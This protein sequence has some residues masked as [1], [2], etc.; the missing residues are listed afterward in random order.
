VEHALKTWKCRHCGRHNLTV[1]ALDG[2]AKCP[3]CAWRMTI[4]P[5]RDYLSSFSTLHP[6]VAPVA[7]DRTEPSRGRRFRAGPVSS[8]LAGVR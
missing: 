1:V 7:A 4:Q 6:E 2:I 3:H 5:S 8:A